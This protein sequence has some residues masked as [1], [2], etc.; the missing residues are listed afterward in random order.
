MDS[1]LIKQ[2]MI[3]RLRQMAK[4]VLR[5]PENVAVSLPV[6]LAKYASRIN[7]LVQI[8]S[9]DGEKNDPLRKFILDQQ[10][11][12]ILVEPFVPNFKKLVSNYNRFPHRLHFENIG[13]ADND[14]VLEFYYLTDITES[15][16]DWYDQ[17]GSFDKATFV[18]NV[19]VVPEL[20]NRMQV[21]EIPCL[22]VSK[23]LDKYNWETV[24]LIHIDA[25]GFDYRI[26]KSLDLARIKPCIILFETD[27]MTQFEMKQLDRLFKQEG[28][29][30]YAEGIDKIAIKN[31]M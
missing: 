13:I 17:V 19:E 24:D 5:R 22:S 29:T 6:V 14:Q 9:N 21:R 15:E 25:E 4:A 2:T 3:A 7:R 23:L 10:P 20:I 31:E 18:K 8:G 30:V 11:E 1:Y 26:I 28:Y 12:G 16:P 27:W